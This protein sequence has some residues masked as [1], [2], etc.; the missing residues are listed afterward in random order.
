MSVIITG[1][2]DLDAYSN[3]IRQ[4]YYMSTYY[5]L[6]GSKVFIEYKNPIVNNNNPN[7]YIKKYITDF[8]DGNDYTESSVTSA[9]SAIYYKKGT[10]YISYS[11]VYNDDTVFPYVTREPFIIKDSWE[12]YNQNNIR[13]N[14]E[15]NLTLP[16]NIEQINIQPNEWGVDDIF[17]TAIYRLQD[18]LEYLISNTQTI[19]TFAPTVFFGWLGNNAGTPASGIKWFTQSYN[20]KYLNNSDLATNKGTSYFSN[21]VDAVEFDDYLFVIDDNKLR[22]FENKAIPKEIIFSNTLQLTSFLINP[23]SIEVTKIED[24]YIAYVADQIQN[25]IYKLNINFDKNNV[26]KNNVDIKLFI[27]GF[28]GLINHN[29]FNTPSQV[30]YSNKNVYV[31]DYNNRGIKQ[32]NSDLN[33]IYT[34]GISE[35]DNDQ[36][37]SIAVHNNG[38]LYVLTKNYNVY[39]FDNLSNIVFEKISVS[40]SNDN[41]A[42]LKISFSE[43]NDFFFILTEQ[44][45]Y[46]YSITGAYITT[47]VIP[48]KDTTKYSNIKKGKNGIIL[49]SSKNCLLKSQDILEVFRLGKGLPYKYWTKDQLKVFKNEFTSDLNYNRSLVRMAQNIKTFRDTLNSKFVLAKEHIHGNV[50]VYFSYIPIN[51]SERPVFSDEVENELL[52]VGVNELHIPSVLNKE[53]KKL[54]D[55]LQQLN[56]FLSIH[57]YTVTNNDCLDSFCWSWNSTSCYK[58]SLPV[59]KTCK[60]NPISFLELSLNQNSNIVYASA[61]GGTIAW[62]N[63]TS[64]CCQKTTT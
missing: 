16:Y 15:I 54:Y 64:K 31:L 41:S 23:V 27:G 55:S 52:S 22:I 13:L 18:S 11:A 36:P 5:S 50:I 30:C 47:L 38:L 7:L 57:N 40:I 24:E 48:K 46:K 43:N 35:F 26:D 34:Y 4:Q 12:I 20:Y 58:L 45:I 39:I 10:Y 49:A 17:N 3:T 56:D 21:V 2:T 32:Y 25:K 29:S 51:V 63:A 1:D 60:I 42:L 28:G 19:N 62:G 44:Y 8:G 37:I 61:S 59:I 33:W 53:F 14:N 6:T 9:A